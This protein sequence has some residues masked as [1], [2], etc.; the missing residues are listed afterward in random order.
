MLAS[1]RGSFLALLGLSLSIPMVAEGQL[2]AGRPSVREGPMMLGGSAAFAGGTQTYQG[3]LT[4]GSRSGLFATGSFGT[5]SI[6]GV[7]EYMTSYGATVGAA[8][9]LNA[10]QAIE[11]CPSVG[12]AHSSLPRILGIQ[13]GATQIMGG[14]AV[15]GA[16]GDR[17]S[18]LQFVPF[19]AV[20]YGQIR[21][22]IDD[23]VNAL[24]G[25]ETAGFVSFGGGVRM[26]RMFSLV[27]EVSFPINQDDTDPIFGVSFAVLLG[28]RR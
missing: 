27:P 13:V 15:G 3:D 6:D 25:S 17:A 24:S 20:Q 11:V 10:G 12:Y 5:T 28:Q 21:A 16:V 23:G 26:H 1:R 9:P 19:A 22:T 4:L 8:I 18:A 7:D 2:C 14:L